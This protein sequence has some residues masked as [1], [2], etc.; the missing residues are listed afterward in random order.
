MWPHVFVALP[1]LNGTPT[2]CSLDGWMNL[3]RSKAL[4]LKGTGAIPHDIDSFSLAM[5]S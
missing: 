4:S 2:F 3:L 1:E 5:I